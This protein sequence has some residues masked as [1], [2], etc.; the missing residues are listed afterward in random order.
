M[1]RDRHRNT[2]VHFALLSEN[3]EQFNYA[4]L[5]SDST[6]Q[7][8][9]YTDS[10]GHSPFY[11][12]ESAASL[13]EAMKTSFSLT[14]V[15][16]PAYAPEDI[17]KEIQ[18]YCERNRRLAKVCQEFK[19]ILQGHYQQKNLLNNIPKN[20][21]YVL[22]QHLTLPYEIDESIA[23]IVFNEVYNKLRPEARMTGPFRE[24]YTFFGLIEKPD[25][26][27]ELLEKYI[28]EGCK[29]NTKVQKTR[30]RPL[31]HSINVQK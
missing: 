22:F 27:I 1:E 18:T 11:T 13:C 14:D 4:V 30:K 5:L 8:I 9:F 7:F 16:L 21:L 26:K 17:R 23:R 2:I 28:N 3:P 10:T 25:K 29:E 12:D 6:Q 19:T 24:S 15:R 20:M 31:R